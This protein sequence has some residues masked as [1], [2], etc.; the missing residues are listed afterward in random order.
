MPDTVVQIMQYVD[1]HLEENI[2]FTQMAEGFALSL[3]TLREEFRKH[4]GLT[5]REYLLE[6]KIVCA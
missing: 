5:L 4:I 3:N 1:S 6:R 2:H